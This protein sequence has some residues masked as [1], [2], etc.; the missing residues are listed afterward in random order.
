MKNAPAKTWVEVSRSALASNAKALA[1]SASD[2]QL[3]AVVKS[4]AYGHGITHVVKALKGVTRWFGVDSVDEAD[5]VRTA[6][7]RARVLVL[8]Y[9][10]DADKARAVKAGYRVVVYDLA[11]ARR[12]S[13]IATS[14]TPAYVHV[15]VETGTSRQGV[16][17][18]DLPAFLRALS[19]LKNLK[20]EG[21]S[22]HYANIEDTTD[23]SYAMQQLQRFKDAL[24]TCLA[25]GIE[26][27]IRHTAC[28]AA[29]VLYPDTHFDMVRAGVSLYGMWSSPETRSAA[30][31]RKRDVALRPA[32][33]W[34]TIVAQVKRVPK[35]TPVSYGLT[36]RV[37][38]DSV[39]AVLPVGY[40]DGYARDLSSKAEV[41]VRGKRAKVLGRICMNMCVVDVTGI[42]G[43]KR[44]D[45][46]VLLGAQKKEAVTAEELGAHAGT[47]NY[48]IV[49]RINPTIPRIAVR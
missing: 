26:P 8:G 36:E 31:K 39:V 28:S 9:V 14:R 12:L 2:A 47:I 40:W 34:K 46:V 1:A 19:R 7:A 21:V 29:I 13:R 45:E 4:N 10:R 11:S 27:E 35:G 32:L 3:M 41:L 37:T 16:D 25:A 42:P 20:V 24:G 22:T 43:V 30:K 17:A 48:E 18:K 15:K 5:T 44:E 6:D 23:P 38:R 49:T 33:T